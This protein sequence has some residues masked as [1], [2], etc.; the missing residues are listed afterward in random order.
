MR[1][2]LFNFCEHQVARKFR[3]IRKVIKK[4]GLRIVSINDEK[5]TEPIKRGNVG[6]CPS[7]MDRR[8]TDINEH[9]IE[10]GAKKCD[11]ALVITV[12]QCEEVS[13]GK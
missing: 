12:I 3:E 10:Y 11:R 9:I 13:G 2:V 4:T 1:Y 6:R 8:Y 5:L 7:C